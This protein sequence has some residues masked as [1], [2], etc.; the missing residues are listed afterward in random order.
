VGDAR[1][2]C[3]RAHRSGIRAAPLPDVARSARGVARV[4]GPR[5]VEGAG[6]DRSARQRDR[7]PHRAAAAEDRCRSR[8]Q[9]DSHRPRRRLHAARGRTVT[10]ASV[11]LRLT[12]WYTGAMVVVLA[13]YA[14]CLLWFVNAGASRALDN[15]L[16]GDFRWAAE[17]AEQKPDGTLTWF[18]G[19]TGDDEDAP[20]L[21]VWSAEGSLV[22]RT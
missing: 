2:S 12:L 16:R 13:I 11:R 21:Q 20:W 19:A 17:M 7:R 9:A 3:D 8:G 5:R 1:R 6:T 4:A 22:Y 10:R 18:E 15:R 14:A